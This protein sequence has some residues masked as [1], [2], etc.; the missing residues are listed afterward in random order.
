MMFNGMYRERSKD[1]ASWVLSPNGTV[2][3]FMNELVTNQLQHVLTLDV[4][5]TST[6]PRSLANFSTMES[7]VSTGEFLMGDQCFQCTACSPGKYLS[8]L[9]T[10]RTDQVCLDCSSGSFSNTTNALQCTLC[11]AGSYSS[12]SGSS[13][14]LAC[15]TCSVNG[16]L[17][18]PC[19]QSS[20]SDV[21]VCVCNSGFTGDG[22]TCVCPAGTYYSASSCLP[23]A[24]GTYSA[25]G[26]S[27]ACSACVNGGSTGVTY[28]GVGSSAYNCVYTCN[29]GYY[30]K[31]AYSPSIIVSQY[32]STTGTTT[33]YNFTLG[34]TF[35]LCSAIT[36]FKFRPII[37]SKLY[38]LVYGSNYNGNGIVK[39]NYTSCD[40]V[41][42]PQAAPI[43]IQGNGMILYNTE[44]MLIFA[45]QSYHR[46]S[47]I[48]P[49]Q[50]DPTPIT[51]VGDPGATSGSLD[52]SVGGQWVV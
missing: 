15:K 20:P 37:V 1:K 49:R 44:T 25:G 28:T 38:T 7:F 22:V 21:S 9:C 8:V 17:V 30:G 32:E 35:T 45:Y 3:Y 2:V 50:A 27:T 18:S 6:T 14:C 26:A 5:S 51:L 4:S 52:S 46:I 10:S 47:Y 48:D 34:Q 42:Y 39:F 23:C 16:Y 40:W 19:P 36:G 31:A 29:T 33:L 24:V 41:F 11:N 12:T 13:S 43:T